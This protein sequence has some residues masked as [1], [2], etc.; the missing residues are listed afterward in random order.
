MKL[1]STFK[2]Y[3]L[4][5]PCS[6]ILTFC[7]SW[8]LSSLATTTPQRKGSFNLMP[9]VMTPLK[10]YCSQGVSYLS[11]NSLQESNSSHFEIQRSSDGI[12]FSNTGRVA[13]QLIS[14]KVVQY[15]FTDAAANEG[16]NY[17]RL[18]YFDNDG[19]YQFSNIIVVHVQIKGIQISAVYPG[20]FVD[21]VNITVASEVKTRGMIMLFDNT[22]KMLVTDQ[23]LFNKGVT[24]HTLDNLSG[25]AKGVYILKVQAGETVLTQQLVK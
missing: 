1:I 16:I 14:D 2:N 24:V 20:P 11:W 5:K 8:Q 4:V 18:K 17:Y 19:H 7:F 25:L 15:K 10:G 6:L 12:N 23:P 3:R 13:A 21:K 22:G 9:I